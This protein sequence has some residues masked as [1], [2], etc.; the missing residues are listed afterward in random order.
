[1]LQ[2]DP[3]TSG[4]LGGCLMAVGTPVYRSRSPLHTDKSDAS[5][6]QSMITAA[7]PN[8]PIC[9][10]GAPSQTPT[11][12]QLQEALFQ[13]DGLDNPA[14][15]LELNEPETPPGSAVVEEVAPSA[16]DTPLPESPPPVS[17]QFGLRGKFNVNTK[18]WT[19]ILKFINQC[20]SIFVVSFLR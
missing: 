11:A 4:P 17:L 19:V 5:S 15:D 14:L 12:E 18:T 6:G 9:S 7:P 20:I 1:M 2:A 16:A 3:F 10:D 8:S 13:V